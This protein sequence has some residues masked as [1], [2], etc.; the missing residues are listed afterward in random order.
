MST[1]RDE[2]SEELVNEVGR[3]LLSLLIDRGY[4]SEKDRNNPEA[5][6]DAHESWM[7]D[8]RTQREDGLAMLKWQS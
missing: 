1:D 7:A 6:L 8:I 3:V 2:P 4:L 5:V